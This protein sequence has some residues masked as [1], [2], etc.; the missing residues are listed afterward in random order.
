M[1][2]QKPKSIKKIGLLVVIFSVFIIAS[3]VMLAF[4]LSATEMGNEMNNQSNESSETITF[5]FSHYLKICLFMILAGTAYLIGGIF[6]MKHK[7]W[8]NQMLSGISLLVILLIWGLMIDISLSTE[9][10]GEMEKYIYSALF[11][12]L[13]YSIPNGL[14]IWFLNMKNVKKHFA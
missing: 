8:A 4:S 2:E 3:N 13:L 5:L 11:A 7:M 10:Q 14:L 9:Q 6:I 12:A 1:N